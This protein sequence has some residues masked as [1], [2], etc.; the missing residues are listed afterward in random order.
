MAKNAS[1]NICFPLCVQYIK[2]NKSALNAHLQELDDIMIS[3]RDENKLP[4]YLTKYRI[5]SPESTF[6]KVKRKRVSLKEIK[7]YAGLRILC[8]FENDILEVHTFI[9][10]KLKEKR[11]GLEKFKIFNWEDDE[12]SFVRR[13]K[14]SYPH[15]LIDNS[16]KPSK[17]KSIHYIVKIQQPRHPLYVEIQL[18]TLLQDVWGELEHSLSYKRGR[19]HPH[20]KNSFRLLSRDMET[21]DYLLKFL[22]EIS[23]KQ[24]SLEKYS[25]ECYTP[26]INFSYED[27]M[28]KPFRQK[29]V[30][31]ELTNYEIF[32]KGVNIRGSDSGWVTKAKRLLKKVEGA[33]TVSKYR[34]T[35][36]KYW[37]EMESAFLYF[38]ENNIPKAL[39]IYQSLEKVVK[40]KYVLYYRLGEI[41]F[42]QK[43]IVKALECFDE[44]E[45]ILLTRGNANPKNKYSIKLMLAL[46]YWVLGPEYID[47]VIEEI[48]EAERILLQNKSAFS[49]D[50]KVRLI[51]N[52]CWYTLEKYLL[53]KDKLNID[54]RKREE[55]FRNAEKQFKKLEK[56]LAGNA[57]R[58]SLDTQAWFCYQA[59]KKTGDHQYLQKAKKYCGDMRDKPIYT[60]FFNRSNDLQQDHIQEIMNTN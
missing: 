40:N 14:Q 35:D 4:I 7:D 29:K 23:D 5:K 32:M 30:R 18:R 34:N 1:T 57:N 25:N 16:E 42:L 50:D 11:Y 2:E 54:K 31:Q 19:V 17:Y 39:D 38:F 37:L 24:D 12:K 59:F 33:V 45:K 53:N 43:E 13:V 55:Y 6:L 49:R 51:N 8:L 52:F 60:S 20:I 21:N 36:T 22:R 56:V 46:V 9:L 26:K 27:E 15:T 28:P 58:N 10:K 48:Q 3:G 47:I 44:S 41:Y